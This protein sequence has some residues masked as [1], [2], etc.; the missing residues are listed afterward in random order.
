MAGNGS[1]AGS[2]RAAGSKGTQAAETGIGRRVI[3]GGMP[4]RSFRWD[5]ENGPYRTFTRAKTSGMTSTVKK[6]PWRGIPAGD[7]QG[8]REAIAIRYGRRDPAV[9]AVR[10]RRR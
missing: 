8:M 1:R 3:G 7:R 4:A 6:N 2:G 9:D 5:S 10:R